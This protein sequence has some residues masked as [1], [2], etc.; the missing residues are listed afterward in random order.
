MVLNHHPD[1]QAQAKDEVN[2]DMFKLITKA[3]EC[4]SNPEKRRFYDSHDNSIDDTIPSEAHAQTGDFFRTFTAVFDINSR[5]SSDP[6]V[7]SLG[8]E[9]DSYEY[10][11]KFYDFWRN[12]KSWREFDAGEEGFDTEIAECREEKR[13][14]E[15][16]NKKI[17]NKLKKSERQRIM[18]LVDRAYRYDPR[19]LKF[20]EEREA[21]RERKKMEKKLLKQKKREEEERLAKEKQ[22]R[23]EEEK[24]KQEE[25]A[26]QQAIQNKQIRKKRPQFRKVCRAARDKHLSDKRKYPFNPIEEHVEVLCK[27]MNLQQFN[28]T[29]KAFS[30]GDGS[31]LFREMV[32]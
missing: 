11:L 27:L 25:E 22:A 29:L 2:D 13:W 10:A 31:K 30:S 20:K 24:R 6:D 14:M 1:K 9:E 17:T 7:P 16:Q 12:F 21:E 3:Y 8:T 28:K 5:W 15:R 32:S 18:T 4:L 23:E 19:I 26:K